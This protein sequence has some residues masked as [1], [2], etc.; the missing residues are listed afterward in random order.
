[1]ASE[2]TGVSE[3]AARYSIALFELADENQALDT[4]A[5]DLTTL[6]QI[7]AESADLRRLV[8]S[9]VISR[10]DQGRAMAAVLDGAGLSELTKRFIGLVAANR[11]LFAIDG[12]I[13]GFLAELARRRGEV[14][15]QVTTAQPL[16]DAQRNAV[17]DA[18]KASIGSK[19]L[20]NTSVD[21]E[22][23]GGMIV[24]FGS[25]MVDTSVRTKLNKLQLAMKASGG[26]V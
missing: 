13:E 5:S 9:P 21:P 16:N 26:S 14:T 18:L 8:R 17:I 1:M 6:K 2:G 10:A 22:L 20:V 4:V 11:R 3:L 15:A 12:M 19:V 24:K 7:L 25:R 23:I